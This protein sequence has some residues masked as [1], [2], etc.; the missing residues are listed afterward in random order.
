MAYKN[1]RPVVALLV[2]VIVKLPLATVDTYQLPEPNSVPALA[3]IGVR[4]GCEPVAIVPVCV[5]VT[6][7]VADPVASVTVPVAFDRPAASC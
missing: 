6:T 2:W 5:G 7:V 1:V 3:V 4:I